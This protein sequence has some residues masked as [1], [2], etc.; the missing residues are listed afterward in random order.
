VILQ[1]QEDKGAGTESEEDGGQKKKKKK[2]KNEK[3]FSFDCFLFFSLFRGSA[4]S[5]SASSLYSH[6]FRI[7]GSWTE[8]I[9]N[10]SKI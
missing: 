4:F 6:F 2:K 3:S 7:A 10:E 8:R 1:E 9:C 5:S